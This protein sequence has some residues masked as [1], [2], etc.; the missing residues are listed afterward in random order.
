MDSSL[1]VRITASQQDEAALSPVIQVTSPADP[2]DQV[3]AD[4]IDVLRQLVSPRT[5]RDPLKRPQDQ[6]VVL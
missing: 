3:Q 6:L 2:L 5:N 4:N 1:V